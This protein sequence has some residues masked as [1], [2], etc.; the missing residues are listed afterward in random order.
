MGLSACNAVIGCALHL[1]CV[2]GL[3]VASCEL[4]TARFFLFFSPCCLFHSYSCCG[5]VS[6]F[7]AAT[8]TCVSLFADCIARNLF[9][10]DQ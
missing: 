4:H 8:L 9:P 7:P 3:L 5:P 1:I 6:S 10:R 2:P